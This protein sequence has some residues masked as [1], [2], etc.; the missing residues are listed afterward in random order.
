MPAMMTGNL[1]DLQSLLAYLS[2]FFIQ[3]AA[4]RFENPLHTRIAISYQVSRLVKLLVNSMHLHR[5][6][7]KLSTEIQVCCLTCSGRPSHTDTKTLIA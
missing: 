5:Q 4:G 1:V 6:T 3:D 7:H 2:S